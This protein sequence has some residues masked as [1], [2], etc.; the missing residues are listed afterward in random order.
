MQ[1]NDKD[2]NPKGTDPGGWRS[3]GGTRPAHWQGETLPYGR[4]QDPR[5]MTFDQRGY[6]TGKQYGEAGEFGQSYNKRERRPPR[7]YARSD[8]SL[9]DDVC[10]ALSRSRVNVSDIMVAVEGGIVKLN[11]S[12]G[13]RDDKFLLEYLAANCPGTVDVENQLQVDPAL[14]AARSARRLGESK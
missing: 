5:T 12:V 13:R 2:D 9:L 4:E 1:E 3:G 10:D 7:G 8:D 11:G 6:G 14:A